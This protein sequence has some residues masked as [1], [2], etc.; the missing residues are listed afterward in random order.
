[1]TFVFWMN[2]P[3]NILH[4]GTQIDNTDKNIEAD[5]IEFT[6]ICFSASQTNVI[7]DVN[8]RMK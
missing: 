3:F 2:Y 6:N 7:A 4:L 8:L 5:L 1:M